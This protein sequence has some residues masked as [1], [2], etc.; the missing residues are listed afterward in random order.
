MSRFQKLLTNDGNFNP[1]HTKLNPRM[2]RL[3]TTHPDSQTQNSKIETQKDSLDYNPRFQLSAI[4]FVN[5]MYEEETNCRGQHA[6]SHCYNG[7][8]P[9]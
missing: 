8:V 2:I 6:D 4:H 1:D 5:A 7:D 9:V 3:Q